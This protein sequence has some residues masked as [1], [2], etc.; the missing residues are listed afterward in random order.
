MKQRLICLCH[1]VC[2]LDG[3]GKLGVEWDALSSLSLPVHRKGPHQKGWQVSRGDLSRPGQHSLPRPGQHSLPHASSIPASTSVQM[4]PTAWEHLLPQALSIFTTF[5]LNAACFVEMTDVSFLGNRH[6]YYTV[7]SC[8][9]VI[10]KEPWGLL[11]FCHDPHLPFMSDSKLSVP[12]LLCLLGW[13]SE[14]HQSHIS[15]VA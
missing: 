9:T 2:L 7:T 11:F 12:C 10:K 8:G 1:H 13:V 5:Q 4:S 15:L 3:V 6:S 14:A